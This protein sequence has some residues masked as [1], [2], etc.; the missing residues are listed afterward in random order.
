MSKRPKPFE[1]KGKKK[2]RHPQ[3]IALE[4]RVV[5]FKM[6]EMPGIEPGSERSDRQASTC[7]GHTLMSC[8]YP[9]RA[10]K[11]RCQQR[12]IGTATKIQPE[13]R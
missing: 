11:A 8:I 6:V 2:T 3:R 4:R 12:L 13:S 1:Y 10:T 5:I 7:V 9:W